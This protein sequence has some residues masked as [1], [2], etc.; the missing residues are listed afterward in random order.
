MTNMNIRYYGLDK[1]G[2]FIHGTVSGVGPYID[3]VLDEH[4]KAGDQQLHI[5]Q[6]TPI[7]GIFTAEE[8]SR[9]RFNGNRYYRD[10]S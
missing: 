4:C 10:V 6:G 7:A 9:F 3:G 8:G 5:I 2:K 1:D